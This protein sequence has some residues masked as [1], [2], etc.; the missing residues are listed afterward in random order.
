MKYTIANEDAGVRLDVFLAR[1]ADVTRSRAGALIKEGSARV[2]GKTE[3]KAGY[4]LRNGDEI[5]FD[6]P[7]PAPAHVEAQDIP[8]RIV[9]ED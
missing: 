8:L 7:E 2:N 5:E 3:T 9:Y 6:I 1:I 4:A